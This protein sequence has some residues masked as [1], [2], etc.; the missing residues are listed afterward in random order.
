MTASQATTEYAT[1]AITAQSRTAAKAER[2]I[3]AQL[4]GHD[5][6]I[7]LTQAARDAATATT[8]ADVLTDLMVS[9]RAGE[10][11]AAAIETIASNY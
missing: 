1:A 7:G 6:L 8:V 2:R 5:D 3:T 10:D 11:L 4:A 9:L